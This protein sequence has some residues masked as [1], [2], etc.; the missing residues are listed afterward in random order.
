MPKVEVTDLNSVLLDGVDAGHLVDVLGNHFAPNVKPADVNPDH[1]AGRVAL[2]AALDTW[3]ANLHATHKAA[4]DALGQQHADT[5]AAHAAELEAQRAEHGKQLQDLIDHHAKQMDQ[6]TKANADLRKQ[7]DALGGT[8]LGQK[9]A[10]EKKRAAHLA[11]IA[12][13]Q[14]ELAKLDSAPASS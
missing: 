11:T 2:K 1:T 7:V 4:L 5:L 14:A 10:L 12:E 6:I 13:H 9:L 8:E 3:R